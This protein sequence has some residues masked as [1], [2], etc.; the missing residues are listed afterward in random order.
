M[1]FELK[2]KIPRNYLHSEDVLTGTVFGN[3]RYFS[4][5]DILLNFLNESVDLNKNK[6]KLK[7]NELLKIF[8]WEK[9]YN[10]SDSIRKYNEP[11]LFLENDNYAI[12]IECK[13][14]S[15]LSEEY[16]IVDEQGTDYSNQLIRYSKILLDKKYEN[17]I[18]IVIFL[19]DHKSIP[20]E[21][22][23]KSRKDIAPTIDLYWLSWNK[24]YLALMNQNTN[25]L[26]PNELLLYKELVAFLERRDM[27]TFNKFIID[28]VIIDNFYYR[29][30][31]RYVNKKIIF[32]W[33]YKK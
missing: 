9:C 28:D 29:K 10:T 14:H 1:I 25:N 8:F 19:T 30:Q 31:Y 17:R 5:Q 11:D 7:T 2:N 4:K 18:K 15:P 6:L 13:Y 33:R 24:L 3:I 16:E 27:V 26:P 23:V 12:I 32:T 22:L 21:I 20:S